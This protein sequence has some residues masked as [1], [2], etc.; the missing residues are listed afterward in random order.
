MDANERAEPQGESQPSPP[1][2]QECLVWQS[3]QLFGPHR[4]VLIQHGG[5]VYRLRKTRNGRLILQ[6]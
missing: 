1:G 2:C 5:E 4:E 6:K 3:A